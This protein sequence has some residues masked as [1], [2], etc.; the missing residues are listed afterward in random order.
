ML[1]DGCRAAVFVF[2]AQLLE[3]LTAG[4]FI[5]V[6]N[7]VVRKVNHTLK[8]TDAHIEYQTN[9]RGGTAQEPNVGYRNC[10]ANVAHALATD[11]A[12]GNTD[13]TLIADNILIAEALV[14]TTVALPV[15]GRPKNALA[16]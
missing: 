7:D 11:N 6:H 14:F 13:A 1:F 3:R 10:Q 8:V 9:A 15:L 5:Q 16:K 4:V 2:L 12:A